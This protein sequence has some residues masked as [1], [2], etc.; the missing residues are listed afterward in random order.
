MGNGLD[1]YI[2][3]MSSGAGVKWPNAATDPVSS[4]L[5]IQAPIPFCHRNDHEH[6]KMGYIGQIG[7]WKPGE[8]VIKSENRNY[9]VAVGPIS[10]KPS[11]NWSESKNAMR[12]E[13]YIL[14]Q[15]LGCSE[16][17]V[18]MSKGNSS[19]EI[20]GWLYTPNLDYYLFDGKPESYDKIL[21]NSNIQ[22]FL[23]ENS[24]EQKNIL[25][26]NENRASLLLKH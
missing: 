25:R 20:F 17:Q 6:L 13:S 19:I 4:I 10:L 5:T 26:I 12:V 15:L 2:G 1:A 11:S 23:E 18:R 8:L 21:G 22:R 3:S 14:R 24:S 9:Y 16:R 7:I